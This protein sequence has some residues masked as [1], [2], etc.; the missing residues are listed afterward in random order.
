MMVGKILFCK[1]VY[2]EENHLGDYLLSACSMPGTTLRAL[3]ACA[4]FY[5]IFQNKLYEAYEPQS[6]LKMR[7]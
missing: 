2:I 7:K 1:V 6:S 5:F 4:H 3:D